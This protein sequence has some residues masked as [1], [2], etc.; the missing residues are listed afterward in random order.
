MN[1][2][3]AM[4][5]IQYKLGINDLWDESNFFTI[6][7][8]LGNKKDLAWC[9]SADDAIMF[10]HEKLNDDHIIAVEF[11]DFFFE[12]EDDAEKYAEDEE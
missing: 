9:N 10:I 2:Q 5:L 1:K 6:Y 8:N 12:N 7:Y 11:D 4:R 3:E